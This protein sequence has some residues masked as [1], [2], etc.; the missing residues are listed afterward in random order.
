[1]SGAYPSALDRFRMAVG[2]A[3][4]GGNAAG[5]VG[6]AEQAVAQ[7]FEDPMLLGLAGRGRIMNGQLD[8]ALVAL[9]R[10]RELAPGDLGTLADLGMCLAL[11][12]RPREALTVF[13]DALARAPGHPALLLLA[14]QPM[15]DLGQ[16]RRAQA[17]LETV[18]AA[19]PGNTHALDRLA[20]L[21]A[22]RGDTAA[23]RTYAERALALQPPLHSATIVLAMADLAE[24]KP[25]A[26]FEHLA[27]VLND[28]SIAPVN[29]AIAYGLL[30]DAL[31][32]QGRYG[33][34]FQAYAAARDMM[35]GPLEQSLAGRES[36]A[37][38]V[39][40]LTSYFRSA[41]DAPWH[42]DAPPEPIQTHV[43]L[44]GF[45]RSGT[46]LLEQALASHP[47]MRTMEE[48]DCL[49]DTVGQYFYAADGMTRFAAL[50][51]VE[52]EKLR[53]EYWARVADAG[54]PTDRA[55][56]VDKE[57]LNSV[58][59][60]M[61]A[62]LFPKAKI[63]FAL[64][65]P[66]DVVLSCFRRRLVMTA[67]A[68][69]LST[70]AGA[71]GFYDAVMTLAMLYRDKLPLATLEVKHEDVVADFDG[72]MRKVCEFLGIAFDPATRDF[73]AHA[74]DRDIKTP[75]AGQILRGLNKDG[76]GQWRRYAAELAP[77]L[78]VLAPW[79][80]RFG[81]PEA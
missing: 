56:F 79:V 64:R 10:A 36:A 63:L 20:N 55:V 47:A 7:G 15:E 68:L 13:D 51:D 23:A 5:A 53:A 73:A 27:S 45:P 61:I 35:R 70:T 46:T 43:F 31:D 44:V 62:R 11:L 67:N 50:D 8:R 14:A 33:E 21:L 65:D 48:I 77:V 38:R 58:H 32:A 80:A 66:R 59:L 19:E 41:P 60:G 28:P 76:A 49:G 34:A 40:R 78:P 26:A 81:Y 4:R 39:R 57:P 6:Y 42:V 1:M 74:R 12:R 30:G 24:G 69:E 29:R 71:A 3:L 17:A 18:I 25:D 9:T 22:R 75:S 37:D 54:A 72:Q 16:L 52:L 2:E